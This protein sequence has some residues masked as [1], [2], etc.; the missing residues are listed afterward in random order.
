MPPLNEPILVDTPQFILHPFGA[1]EMKRIDS[2]SRGIQQL[3]SSERHHVFLQHKKLDGT[4]QAEALLHTALFNQFNGTGQWYFITEKTNK[5]TIGMIEL[6]S[7]SG[8]KQHYQL[9]N[10]PYILE[11]CLSE[12]Y[13]RKGIMG[14]V[15]PK[16]VE[17]LK[18]KEINHIGAV[19]N[20][21]NLKA[22][23]VLKKSGIDKQTHFDA[24]SNL[25]H[26]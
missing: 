13:I 12:E 2:L 9:D 25:Y 23:K 17:C 22:I 5:K 3:F 21:K 18:K 8:A 1:T 11:F 14:K 7:P 6:I 15:L 24:I 19:V 26:N 16:F 10:Y 4:S 20:L